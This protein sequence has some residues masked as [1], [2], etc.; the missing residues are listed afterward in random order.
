MVKI[1]IVS[2]F[3]NESPILKEWIDHYIKEEIDT[4]FLTDNGST[5][6]YLPILEPYI[7]SG[8]VVLNINPKKH[9]Q[10][11]HLNFFLKKAKT[12]DWVII[13]DL[14]EFMYARRGYT[15]IKQYLSDISPNVHKI[16]VPW[17]LFGSSGHIKQPKS[18]IQNFV[19]RRKFPETMC[20]SCYDILVDKK[21]IVRGKYLRQIGVHNSTTEDPHIITPDNNDILKDDYYHTN[22]ET[23]L[24]NSYLHLNH[25]RIQSWESFKKKTKRGD[26]AN[27]KTVRNKKYF[28]YF[29]YKDMVDEELKNKKYN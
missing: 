28:K 6:N 22:T 25:Y 15:T 21:T 9:S 29:D 13:I 17:K 7:K 16:Y 19:H 4:I 18:V 5:D 24:K 11:E 14:D 1:C 10:V 12:Y 27:K 2:V 8:K 3:K 26:A 20:H 23:K